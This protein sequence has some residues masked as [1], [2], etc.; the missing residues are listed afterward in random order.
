MHSFYSLYKTD[1]GGLHL[2]KI[3]VEEALS[4]NENVIF[5]RGYQLK[6]IKKVA[7]I[8]NGV[9]SANGG[10]TEDTS[11][12]TYSI[13]DLYDFVKTFDK[14]FTPAPTVSKVVLNED[15]TP[16]VFYHGTN[17]KFTTF[18]SGHK[19]TRG[20]LNFGEGYYFAADKSYA[21]NYIEKDGRIIEAYI[22]LKK[23]YFVVGNQFTRRLMPRKCS[24]RFCRTL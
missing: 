17:A 12:T 4:N 23:P 8:P 16:K 6:D 19:R 11:T 14:D 1:D 5:K 3:F 20:R 7:D 21:E 15:G 2:I 24:T 18:E 22:S 13:S 10:L 9:H